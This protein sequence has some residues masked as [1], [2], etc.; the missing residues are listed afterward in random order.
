M[1]IADRLDIAMVMTVEPGL[2]RSALHGRRGPQDR[3][4]PA[5][6]RVDGCRSTVH[7][8]GGVNRD[9]A[10]P[11]VPSGRTS[12]SSARR[13]SSAARTPRTRSTSCA[14]AWA[15]ARGDRRRGRAATM[16]APRPRGSSLPTRGSMRL[17]LQRVTRASVTVEG[18][19]SVGSAPACWSWSASVTTT[20]SRGPTLMAGRV[21]DLRIF[22]DE[23]GQDQPDPHRCRWFG[24]R[25]QPVHALRRHPE[26]PP[27]VVPRRSAARRSAS[28]LRAVR[29]ALARRGGCPWSAACS[30]P[31]WRSS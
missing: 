12:W 19:S 25:R 24:A 29:D 21:V 31:R 30:A 7:V 14:C 20:T 16:T 11:W 27:A 1:P 10:A 22:R 17:L 18:E 3:R 26:G 6:R 23:R 2:R 28:P 8:D 4:R 5:C 9:T 15:A 13:S